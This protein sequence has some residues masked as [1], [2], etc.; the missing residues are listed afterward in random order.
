MVSSLEEVEYTLQNDL[1]KIKV[2]IENRIARVSNRRS[3][4]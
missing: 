2:R 3:V 1:E 4:V